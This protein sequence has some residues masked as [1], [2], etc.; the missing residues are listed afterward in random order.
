MCIAPSFV[1]QPLIGPLSS[2]TY[3]QAKAGSNGAGCI[4]FEP[5][6]WEGLFFLALGDNFSSSENSLDPSG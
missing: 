6:G 3:P 5:R 1:A 2:S 4:H